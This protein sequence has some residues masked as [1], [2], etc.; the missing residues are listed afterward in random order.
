MPADPPALVA[1][2]LTQRFVRC[3]DREVSRGERTA[4]APGGRQFPGSVGS[5]K[6]GEGSSAALLS[7]CFPSRLEFHSRKEPVK[8][9]GLAH[10]PKFGGLLILCILSS[11]SSG[12]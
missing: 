12:R 2:G 4:G 8:L 10:L 9:V 3:F 11:G 1:A 7:S 6:L 5:I